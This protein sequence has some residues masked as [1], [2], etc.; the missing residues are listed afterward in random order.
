LNKSFSYVIVNHPLLVTNQEAIVAPIDNTREATRLQQELTSEVRSNASL[1]R[2][3]LV[4]RCDDTAM[5]LFYGLF[6]I[7]DAA[8]TIKATSP[9][10]AEL[11]LAIGFTT[12]RDAA[13]ASIDA[14]KH[15]EVL[16]FGPTPEE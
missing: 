6:D 13:Q 4:Q 16:R 10:I 5:P 15:G 2:F 8:K 9:Q 11:M 14:L 1:V 12:D 3:A 7:G